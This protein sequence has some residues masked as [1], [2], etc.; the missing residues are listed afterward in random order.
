MTVDGGLKKN[1][2][3]NIHDG[4]WKNTEHQTKFDEKTESKI[5]DGNRVPD[6]C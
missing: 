1:R 3:L 5:L 6:E 2:L 4:E